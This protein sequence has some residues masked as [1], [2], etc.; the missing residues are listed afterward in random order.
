[1]VDPVGGAC[2]E[3]SLSS[4]YMASEKPPLFIRKIRTLLVTCNQCFG[5]RCLHPTWRVDF[6]LVVLILFLTTVVYLLGYTQFSWHFISIFYSRFS[7]SE[8]PVMWTTL[9]ML[10]WLSWLFV[11]IVCITVFLLMQYDFHHWLLFIP[12]I[13]TSSFVLYPHCM[14]SMANCPIP[15]LVRISSYASPVFRRTGFCTRT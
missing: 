9:E 3:T 11:T 6:V 4:V 1:M 15:R 5:H 10:L 2:L 14:E 13:L 8:F 12:S 7:S